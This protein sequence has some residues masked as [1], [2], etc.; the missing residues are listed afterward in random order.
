MYW[1]R[2]KFVAARLRANAQQVRDQAQPVSEFVVADLFE[3]AADALTIA[4]IVFIWRQWQVRKI[5]RQL[6]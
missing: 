4:W 6:V 3:D 5:N 1:S 2:R